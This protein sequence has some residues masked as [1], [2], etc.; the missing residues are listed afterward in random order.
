M[1]SIFP[2]YS[3]QMSDILDLSTDVVS[4][5]ERL[6]ESRKYTDVSF[7]VGKEPNSKIFFAHAAVLCAR[8]TYFENR[9]TRDTDVSNEVQKTALAFEDVVPDVFEILLR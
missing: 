3:S 4:D 1:T 7:H 5:L 6:Y 8:S 2:S 9:L